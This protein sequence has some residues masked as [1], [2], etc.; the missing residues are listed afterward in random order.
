MKDGVTHFQNPAT[1]ELAAIA[2]DSTAVLKSIPQAEAFFDKHYHTHCDKP[3]RDD[4]V[5]MMALLISEHTDSDALPPLEFGLAAA[6]A[7][8]G[9]H[10]DT[11]LG[12]RSEAYWRSAEGRR[13]LA[14]F[15]PS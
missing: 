1:G 6:A 3:Y 4:F 13:M 8:Y 12:D 11:D 2:V 15:Q 14:H 5:M 9:L 10:P 7:V